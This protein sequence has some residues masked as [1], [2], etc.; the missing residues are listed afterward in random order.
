[1]MEIIEMFRSKWCWITSGLGFLVSL[2]LV[3]SSFMS[4][5][6]D[7]LRILAVGGFL[8]LFPL[9]LSC[10][11]RLLVK[12]WREAKAIGGGIAHMVLYMLGFVAL[13]SCFVGGFCGV[14]LG[15]SL[16]FLVLPSGIAGTFLHNSPMILLGVDG[17]LLA[18]L[19]YMKCFS[20]ES[21]EPRLLPREAVR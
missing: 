8:V 15:T 11:I 3:W 18:G 6:F 1:M 21:R 12:R 16:L 5:R 9:S 4:G 14:S 10:N 17:L 2:W 7:F 19:W 20:E 13:Q